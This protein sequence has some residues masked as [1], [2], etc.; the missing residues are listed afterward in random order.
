MAEPTV[1]DGFV[2]A[3]VATALAGVA[4]PIVAVLE[5]TRAQR[6]AGDG[7]LTVGPRG[8]RTALATALKLLEKRAPRG[9]DADRLVSTFSPILALVPTLG[10]LSILPAG[11]ADEPGSTLPLALALPLLATGAV[12]LAGHGG[13]SRLALLSALRLVALRA[14][15]LVVVGLACVAAARSAGSV[16][17]ADVA[18]AQA[19]PL[20][21][22]VPRWGVLVSP[23]SFL[24]CLLALAI[25]AQQV[26][27]MRT[28]PS[29][30]E[31]WFGDAT[32]PVLLGYRVFESLDLL[33]CAAILA[34]VF[35]GAWHV[36]GV[37]SDLG[38]VHVLTLALKTVGVLTLVVLL[39]NALPR[40]AHATAVRTL[41][42]VLAPLALSGALIGALFD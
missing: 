37:T 34:V 22:A 14:A 41:W 5:R 32:G 39:R 8:A 17:L 24:A 20:W 19:A 28:E 13:G 18:R 40:L 33:A 21:W 4:L 1:I 31:P 12:A 27:R 26:Q 7:S 36:P 42:L 29:L 9:P 30:A 16:E 25:H 15:A 35:G 11:P 38:A 10:V 2:R 6:I 3:L 23:T